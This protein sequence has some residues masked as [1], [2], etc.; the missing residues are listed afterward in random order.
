M[1]EEVEHRLLIADLIQ[2]GHGRANQSQ[3]KRRK[4]LVLWRLLGLSTGKGAHRCSIVGEG[5][6]LEYIGTAR[7][8]PWPVLWI[9]WKAFD[10][11]HILACV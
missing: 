5:F 3:R 11:M 9:G 2:F 1:Q 7:K 8:A 4:F 6:P 10:R